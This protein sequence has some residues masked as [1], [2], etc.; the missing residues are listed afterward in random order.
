M[1]TANSR[2]KSSTVKVKLAM[3]LGY[4]YA[5][6]PVT[7]CALSEKCSVGGFVI[8][9]VPLIVALPSSIFYRY[10]SNLEGEHVLRHVMFTVGFAS[11][12]WLVDWRYVA[13]HISESWAVE[14]C[15]FM[16]GAGLTLAYFCV[17][18]HMENTGR[19]SLRT[20][21]GDVTVLPLTLVTIG[22]IFA[23]VPDQ[24]F[25]SSRAATVSVPVI[26]AWATI[27]LIAHLD[28][29]SNSDTRILC[30][31]SHIRAFYH[32][33][34]A[35][36]VVAVAHM[37]V[38]ELHGR[39]ILYVALST[40]AA[41]FAQATR[42]IGAIPDVHDASAL[43]LPA[44]CVLGY[45]EGTVCSILLDITWLMF[46]LPVSLPLAQ[47]AG[48]V[49]AGRSWPLAMGPLRV[50]LTTALN[51]TL[52]KRNNVDASDA[53]VLLV[54]ATSHMIVSAALSTYPMRRI[55]EVSA[56]D[57]HDGSLFTTHNGAIPAV[58]AQHTPVETTSASHVFSRLD[59]AVRDAL[60]CDSHA[61][62][63]LWRPRST[64]SDAVTLIALSDTRC[65]TLTTSDTTYSALKC[66]FIASRV[67]RHNDASITVHTYGD[68]GLRY[69]LSTWHG[70][71]SRLE[72]TDVLLL[73]NQSRSECTVL[74][75]VATMT[76]G[77]SRWTARHGIQACPE[78][79]WRFT[80]FRGLHEHTLMCKE[81]SGGSARAFESRTLRV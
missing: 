5:L 55:G 2:K 11:S 50:V 32:I 77:T 63:D 61:T 62:F 59:R 49:V 64:N 4:L 12:V 27:Y 42:P 69:P 3:P 40:S 26:V 9:F 56:P 20:H 36:F 19:W 70:V 31:A 51:W 1:A 67:V 34:D 47:E 22:V 53:V 73:T 6:V 10:V 52:S 28:F 60:G 48:L 13:N 81:R 44:A 30:S 23:H 35:S 45:I 66:R 57:T 29:A 24:A 71:I 38:I 75:R 21:F 41:V 8:A 76:S 58:N 15:I 46:V 68:F 79:N 17:A 43:R 80:V 78:S 39:G 18:H 14:F 33:T 65:L 16:I 7:W 74:Q 25:I 37:I 72:G 54:L